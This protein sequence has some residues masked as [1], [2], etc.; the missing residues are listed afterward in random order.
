MGCKRVGHDFATKQQQ[1][2]REKIKIFL[3]KQKNN[4]LGHLEAV[5]LNLLELSGKWMF[6]LSY[7]SWM[8]CEYPPGDLPNPGI[9]PVSPALQVNSLPAVS[10][11][12]S[13]TKQTGL[14]HRVNKFWNGMSFYEDGANVEEGS[15]DLEKGM[16]NLWW[17]FGSLDQTLPKGYVCV[18]IRFLFF[19]SKFEVGF[20]HIQLIS[21]SHSI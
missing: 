8:W 14:E 11:R 2:Q 1:S 3:W 21:N 20:F 4:L 6:T 7:W 9:K 5:K 17:H 10:H 12:G 13:P 18:L 16:W 15:Q 19:I